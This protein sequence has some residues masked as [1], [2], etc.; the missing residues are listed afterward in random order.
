MSKDSFKTEKRPESSF[1][2][3]A[4][5]TVILFD[6]RYGNTDDDQVE[7]EELGVPDHRWK[8]RPSTVL[9]LDCSASQLC[10]SSIE[11]RNPLV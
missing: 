1:E 2:A 6:R 9:L 3:I 11:L 8:R 7:V 10:Q 4:E 5:I